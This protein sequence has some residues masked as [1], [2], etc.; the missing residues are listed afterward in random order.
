VDA[1]AKQH[2]ELGLVIYANSI[3]LTPGTV[4]LEVAPGTI[5]VHALHPDILKDLYDGDMD[6]RVP[7]PDDQH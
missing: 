6:A 7:D 3:T 5:R 1:S 4:S 2:S